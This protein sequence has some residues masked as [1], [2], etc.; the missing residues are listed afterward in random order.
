MDLTCVSTNPESVIDVTN[1]HSEGLYALFVQLYGSIRDV[2]FCAPRCRKESLAHNQVVPF[3]PT[4]SSLRRAG[5]RQS[6]VLAG[7]GAAKF[8]LG[9]PQ[10]KEQ[11]EFISRDAKTPRS[12][13]E[14]F[15]F[16]AVIVE[17]HAVPAERARI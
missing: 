4:L 3:H 6:H 15:I 2:H 8:Y 11:G 17:S 5:A 9:S 10:C 7:K 13:P 14:C 16:P 12:L 1:S